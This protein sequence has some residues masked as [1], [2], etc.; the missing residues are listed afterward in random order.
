[1]KLATSYRSFPHSYLHKRIEV[2]FFASRFQW[3]HYCDIRSIRLFYFFQAYITSFKIARAS[4]HV[5]CMSESFDSSLGVSQILRGIVNKLMVDILVSPDKLSLFPHR[6]DILC[7][8]CLW[9]MM[10]I[11]LFNDLNRSSL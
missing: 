8:L 6:Q 7:Y 1:M 5:L 11:S 3:R 4:N 9:W 10:L 2:H